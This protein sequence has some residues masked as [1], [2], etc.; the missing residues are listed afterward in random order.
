MV[1]IFPNISTTRANTISISAR[2]A[3]SSF[4]DTIFPNKTS[5]RGTLNIAFTVSLH[6]LL[7]TTFPNK[8]STRVNLKNIMSLISIYSANIML[9]ILSY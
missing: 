8:T 1:T 7:V 4:Y 5:T 6:I 2:S 9:I 3:I